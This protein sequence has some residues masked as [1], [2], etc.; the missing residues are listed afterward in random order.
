[1]AMLLTCLHMYPH[2]VYYRGWAGVVEQAED[3]IRALIEMLF[4]FFVPL[5]SSW[6]LLDQLA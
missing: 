6:A 3:D 2:G 4:D 1:M 5:V